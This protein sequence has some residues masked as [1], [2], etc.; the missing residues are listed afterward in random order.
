MELLKEDSVATDRVRGKR[1]FSSHP[2]GS[3][4]SW[5][6]TFIICKSLFENLPAGSKRVSP[7]TISSGLMPS[8]AQADRQLSRSFE[9][10]KPHQDFKPTWVE[11][12]DIVDGNT[13]LLRDGIASIA[14]SYGIWPHLS[15]RAYVSGT[16]QTAT[17]AVPNRQQIFVP[18]CIVH[19]LCAAHAG[20]RP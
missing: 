5:T 9:G 10:A 3:S 7:A 8:R 20:L 16:E 6:V 4:R 2:R 14:L 18:V 13:T 11:L 17:I 12:L 1:V 15:A 19:G